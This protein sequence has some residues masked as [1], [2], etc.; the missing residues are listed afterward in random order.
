MSILA[1]VCVGIALI[2]GIGIGIGLTQFAK[3]LE[4]QHARQIEAEEAKEYDEWIA[5]ARR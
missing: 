5:I 3:M 4:H 2:G 1:M